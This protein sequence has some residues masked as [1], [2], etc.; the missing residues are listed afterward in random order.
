MTAVI[1]ANDPKA[2]MDNKE[3]EGF[4][5][6]Y[7]AFLLKSRASELEKAWPELQPSLEKCGVSSCTL[8]P[9]ESLMTASITRRT[10]QPSDSDNFN[11]KA[12]RLLDLLATTNVPPSLAIELALNDKITYDL[13][14]IGLQEDG[15]AWEY[16]INQKRFIERRDCFEKHYLEALEF[17]T[18]C[19]LYLGANTLTAV[20][21]TSGWSVSQGLLVVRNIVEQ[22]I[23][24]GPD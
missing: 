1:E 11:Y 22:R 21:T 24:Y 5:Y 10:T 17:A 6:Y 8:N 12:H 14:K 2:M 3:E 13:I 4:T 16:G 23:R 18:G 15:F 9:T 19:D 7:M 20:A